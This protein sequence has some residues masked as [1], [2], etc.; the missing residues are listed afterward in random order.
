MVAVAAA[1]K[2]QPT[3]AMEAAAVER[4]CVSSSVPRWLVEELAEEEVEV[5]PQRGLQRWHWPS[6]SH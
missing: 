3:I 2:V 6:H 5:E 4:P 1:R